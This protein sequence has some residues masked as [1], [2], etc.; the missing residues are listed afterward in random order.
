MSCCF[1]TSVIKY[2]ITV[3]TGDEAEAGCNELILV[4]LNGQMGSTGYRILKDTE[5][6]HFQQGQVINIVFRNVPT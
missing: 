5:Q 4:K 1:F 6:K 2:T 3:T